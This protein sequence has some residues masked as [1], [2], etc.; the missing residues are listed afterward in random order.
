MLIHKKKQIMKI[1]I[2]LAPNV[3]FIKDRWIKQ[4]HHELGTWS[5]LVQNTS[6]VHMLWGTKM[7]YAL[8]QN[9]KQAHRWGQIV[10]YLYTDALCSKMFQTLSQ[11]KCP[12]CYLYHSCWFWNFHRNKLT[13]TYTELYLILKI[14][15]IKWFLTKSFAKLSTFMLQVGRTV[16]DTRGK[17]IVILVLFGNH[18]NVIQQIF[19][20]RECILSP[21]DCTLYFQ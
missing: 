21:I 10:Q 13:A 6:K 20:T 11:L 18:Y 8:L 14:H 9:K 12:F 15:S 16:S 7:R 1:L 3:L 17:S 5:I 19:K 2:A 4:N